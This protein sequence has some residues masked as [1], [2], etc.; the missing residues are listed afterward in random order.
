MLKLAN[1]IITLS[2]NV[3]PGQGKKSAHILT[4]SCRSRG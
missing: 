1:R 4:M 2:D 3:M